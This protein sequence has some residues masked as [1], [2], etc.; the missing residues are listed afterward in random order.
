MR[1]DPG[2]T[3]MKSSEPRLDDLPADLLADFWLRERVERLAGR[4]ASSAPSSSGLALNDAA[5]WRKARR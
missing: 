2:T 1:P 3:A 5:P 4:F